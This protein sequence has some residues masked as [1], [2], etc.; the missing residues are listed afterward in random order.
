MKSKRKKERRRK[1]ET[2]IDVCNS[3]IR[4]NGAKWKERLEREKVEREKD[5]IIIEE[6]EKHKREREERLKRAKIQIQELL[7]RLRKKTGEVKYPTGKSEE[8]VR[9]RV[10]LWRNYRE[11]NG[12]DDV[13]EEKFQSQILLNI[14]ERPK[15]Y[16]PD[17]REN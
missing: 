14:R 2:L 4:E 3:L 12:I 8:W 5:R 9:K 17:L 13:E 15:V 11:V 6:E 10:S 7:Y 1:G 16:V